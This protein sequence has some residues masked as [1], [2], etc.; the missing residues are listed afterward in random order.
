MPGKRRDKALEADLT[1]ML[2]GKFHGIT[3]TTE[4]SDRWGRMSVSFR[5]RG[6]AD[7]LPE[8]R[9]HRLA[10]S[11]PSEFRESRMAG[12]VWLELAPKESVEAFL[13]LPRSEDI[14][15]RQGQIHRKLQEL[16]FFDA[17]SKRLGASPGKSCGGDF[18]LTVAALSSVKASSNLARDAKLLFIGYGAYCDCQV[19]E[20]VKPAPA[21]T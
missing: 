6:F 8:E 15:R 5:W 16:G 2:S 20:S 19:L 21:G 3:V 12:F 14:A 9:F 11:I 7:L 4:H 10:T 13:K 17:L 18:G 1:E